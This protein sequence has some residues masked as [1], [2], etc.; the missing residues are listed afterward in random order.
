M[1]QTVTSHRV[2]GRHERPC[3]VEML[4]AITL[5]GYHLSSVVPSAQE[6]STLF[7][8]HLSIFALIVDILDKY[9]IYDVNT[10]LFTL[11]T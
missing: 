9:H 8:Y 4:E 6:C 11:W 10:C 2:L 3:S 5:G 1:N 7:V